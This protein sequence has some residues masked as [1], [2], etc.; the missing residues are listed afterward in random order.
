MKESIPIM[1]GCIAALGVAPVLAQSTPRAFFVP[2]NELPS[3]NPAGRIQV[4]A[5][6]GGTVCLDL[7][8]SSPPPGLHRI[9]IVGIGDAYGGDSGNVSLDCASAI[10]DADAPTHP[11]NNLNHVDLANCAGG[12]YNYAQLELAH[13]GG[14]GIGNVAL[15]TTGNYLGEAC[16]EISSDACGTFEIYYYI[17]GTSNPPLCACFTP[18]DSSS[19]YSNQQPACDGADIIIGAINDQCAEA[20]SAGVGLMLA[21]STPYD[22]SCASSDA[23]AASCSAMQNG[24]W[25][26]A[27]ASC[28][29]LLEIAAGL[30]ADYAVY[31]AGV[32]CSPTEADEIGCNDP[33]VPVEQGQTYLI[34]IASDDGADVEGDF[35]LTCRPLCRDGFPP[36][37]AET[38]ADCGYTP[39]V[40]AACE[41]GLCTGQPVLYG[42]ANR[43]DAV[44]IFDILCV[45]DG[46]AGNFTECPFDAVDL[47]PCQPDGFDFVDIFDILAI[48][49][50][51]AGE[52]LCCE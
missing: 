14:G 22:T 19:C 42:D 35:A 13:V 29:G 9:I 2:A 48:L 30:D 11:A 50:A 28:T 15:S 18:P 26:S 4:T 51:F 17:L 8:G 27:V 37:S 7:C 47:Y 52:N 21:E 34:R 23:P 39:C 1:V 41:S 12:S 6:Q 5:T 31:A 32:G 25:F 49:D 46:F 43:D 20:K 3:T 24:V 16:W 44:D 10:I 36:G 45:L 33:F 40:T 38:V